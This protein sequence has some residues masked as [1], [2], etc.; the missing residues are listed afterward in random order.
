MDDDAGVLGHW[1]V[2][3]GLAL[4]PRQGTGSFYSLKYIHHLTF[5]DL[6]NCSNHPVVDSGSLNQPFRRDL[7]T[8]HQSVWPRKRGAARMVS[9]HIYIGQLST[10]R[11]LCVI[12]HVPEMG[13]DR[14]DYGYSSGERVVA[15]GTPNAQ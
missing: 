8:E 13:P 4:Q 1:T 3:A 15:P 7:G 12:C 10:P 9:S 5:G 2:V 11:P 6:A 14:A